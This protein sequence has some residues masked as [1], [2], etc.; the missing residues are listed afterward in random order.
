[1]IENW[2]AVEG[3]EGLYE[4]SDL[5]RV[6]SLGREVNSKGGSTAIK[7]GKILALS[8]NK[9]GYEYLFLYKNNISINV[10]VHRLVG[11]AF[12]NNPNNKPMINHEDGN[13]SNNNVS[14]L[15]WNT[16][17]ENTNHAFNAG[18]RCKGEDSSN[19]KLSW[20]DVNKIRELY[21]T[22]LYLQKELS[23]MFGVSKTSIRNVLTNKT[24]AK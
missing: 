23:K 11:L 15:E 17:K 9:Y 6:K 13:K 10:K 3:Y 22:E 24:Y 4:I 7:K 8:T 21:K 19:A 12:I 2:K 16:C 5:G 1:M 20:D 14:N 18:L